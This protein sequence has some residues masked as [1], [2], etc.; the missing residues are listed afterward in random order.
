VNITRISHQ[1]LIKRV[2]K[3]QP[4]FKDKKDKQLIQRQYEA[5]QSRID[6]RI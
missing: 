3:S 1:P 5:K 4:L 6:I 2:G